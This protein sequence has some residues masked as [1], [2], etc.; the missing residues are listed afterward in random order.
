MGKAISTAIVG[1]VIAGAAVCLI[2]A[3]AMFRSGQNP[4]SNAANGCDR[5]YSVSIRAGSVDGESHYLMGCVFQ[6]RKKHHLAIE[7][8]KRAVQ[9][10]P[11][12]AAAYNRWGV[13]LDAQGDYDE[14]VAAYTTALAIDQNLADVYNNLGYSYLL[15]GRFEPAIESLQ[16]AVALDGGNQRYQN[17]LGLAYAKSGDY[18]AAFEAFS[19]G[20]D[21]S[22]AHLNIARL[23]YRNRLYEKAAIHFSRASAEKPLDSETEKGFAAATSLAY[24]HETKSIENEA[25][26]TQTA[27]K[28][29][30]RRDDEDFYTIPAGA[31]ETVEFAEIDDQAVRIKATDDFDD[32]DAQTTD[33]SSA[34]GI[35]ALEEE[36]KI[37]EE[38]LDTK[39]LKMFDETQAPELLSLET[40]H[41]EKHSNFRIK[42]EVSNGNGVRRMARSVGDFLKRN[43]MRV[44]RLTNADHFGHARTVIYYREGYHDEAT[45]VQRLLPGLSHGGNLVS[46]RLDRE[47]V[48]VLIGRDL[49]AFHA[50]LVREVDVEI[51]NGNGVDGMAGRLGRHL[52]REGFR[53]GRLT[54]ANHFE[55]QKTV[56]FYGKGKADQA[57]RIADV[58]P[59]DDRVRMVELDRTGMHVQILMGADMVF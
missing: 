58:L 15:Q 8:F 14:A 41:R 3:C 39:S 38:A 54:N 18:E 20:G 13:S 17:N 23:Y 4:G 22:K 11:G 59:G 50:A 53:V 9:I 43:G 24:I 21:E 33:T 32:Q 44:A 49:A 12:H 26:L 1:L 19:A 5:T 46:A 2:T 36:H 51:A 35:A 48:R 57:M 55:Y 6:E 45:Q 27:E 56:L 7:A 42:I 37:I 16:K 30:A 52:R 34:A 10:D 25:P 31:I 29:I 47:P 28:Q 40:A